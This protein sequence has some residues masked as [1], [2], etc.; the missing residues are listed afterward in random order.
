MENLELAYESR[1]TRN[2]LSVKATDELSG[3]QAKM[4]ENNEI[5]CL[6]P[7]RSRSMNGVYCLD[8]DMTG[9]N[10]LVDAL[11]SRQIRGEKAKKM[12]WE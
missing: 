10:R 11:E 3:F 5:P 6:L 9:M 7:M 8:Y 12:L 2:Y 1:G 4:L